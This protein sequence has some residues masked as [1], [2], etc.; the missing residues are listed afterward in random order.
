MKFLI[1]NALSIVVAQGLTDLGYDAI[2]VRE[3]Q[4]QSASDEKIFLRAQQERR[5]IISAD[6]DFAQIL[7]LRN[8]PLPSLILFRK[9]S[10]RNPVTQI[11]LLSANLT[12]EVLTALSE[13]SV[14]VFEEERIR[15]RKLPFKN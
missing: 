5:V 14:V 13:G 8:A 15:I 9:S 10:S 12:E 1:D 3:I 7:A 4:M 6:T 11:R 2:H